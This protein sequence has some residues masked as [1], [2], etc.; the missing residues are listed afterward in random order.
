MHTVKENRLHI[1]W[2]ECW[3]RRQLYIYS[4]TSQSSRLNDFVRNMSVVICYLTH[5]YFVSTFQTKE[6]TSRM[7]FDIG[8]ERRDAWFAIASSSETKS[9]VAIFPRTFQQTSSIET[10]RT[11]R[12]ILWCP[13]KNIGACVRNWRK[14]QTCRV[15]VSAADLRVIVHIDVLVGL[16]VRCCAVDP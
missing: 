5:L 4:S 6:N 1:S 8:I 2:E 3:R 14:L 10:V 16:V 15:G 9:D 12:N 7:K 11:T 13:N